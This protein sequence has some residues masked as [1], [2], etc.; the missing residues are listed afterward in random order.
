MSN[1]QISGKWWECC[2]REGQCPLWFGRDLT[3]E[4]G[5]C[6]TLQTWLIKE[7]KI[8][9]VDMAGV[10]LVH[11][12]WEVGLTMAEWTLGVPE[13]GA[14]YIDE[15]TTEEQRKILKP[16]AIK[17]LDRITG[18]KWK[19]ITGSRI[20]PIE[21]KEESWPVVKDLFPLSNGAFHMKMPYGEQKIMYTV[22][23]DLKN[24]IQVLNPVEDW[25]GQARICDTLYW[26][27]FDYGKNVD[28]KHTSGASV[29][30]VMEGEL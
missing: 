5:K 10:T 25:M 11:C 19:T 2:I 13:I 14:I 15:K 29:D 1:W 16:G 4:E 27:Y 6:A 8:Q 18:G 22:G 28:K 21:I 26:K 17:G 3:P 7:G 12:I 30:W 23:G 20:V 9:N 24:P